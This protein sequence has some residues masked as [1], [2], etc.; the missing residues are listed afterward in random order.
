VGLRDALRRLKEEARGE[1]VEIPQRDDPP[2]HFTEHDLKDAFVNMVERAGA[3]EDAPP[4]HPV[5]EAVRNSSDPDW[6]ESFYHIGDPDQHTE[7]QED[8]SSQAGRES[9]EKS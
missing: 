7:G 8:L 6:L 3:G 5:L 2:K 1:L 4:E 9:R